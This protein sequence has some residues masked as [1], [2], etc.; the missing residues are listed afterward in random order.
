MGK[1][2]RAW[3]IAVVAL[4][5]VAVLAA[6]LGRGFL[7]GDSSRP[8][9]TQWATGT[10]EIGDIR[11]TVAG[12]A[13]LQPGQ[14]EEIRAQVAG[15]ITRIRVK[16]GETVVR[17]QI[18]AELDNESVLLS[19]EQAQLAY[20]TERQRLD[21]MRRG[22][23]A[24]VSDTAVR[25][26]E[27]KVENARLTL[28][29]RQR[30]ADEL[31]VKAPVAGLV[32]KLDV[33]QGDEVPAG[34]SLLTLWEGGVA[35]VRLPVP[36]TQ[37]RQVKVGDSASVIISPLPEAAMVPLTLGEGLIYGLKVGDL[38]VA[39]FSDY[40]LS[41]PPA[42]YEGTVAS[43]EPSGNQF[44]VYCRF[45]TVPAGIADGARAAVYI[46]PS[47]RWD[48]MTS[49]DAS[50]IMH[51]AVD[52]RY[53]DTQHAA[54]KGHS[55]RVSSIGAQG[56]KDAAG[57][58]TFE[59]IL[60]LPELPSGARA[61]MTAH[62]YLST[63]AGAPVSALSTLETVARNLTTA[64]GGKVVGLTVAEGSHAV[65]GQV[66]VV[67]ENENVLYQLEQAR[68][69]LALQ[70]NSLKELTSPEY[71]EDEL[72]SQELKF[73]QAELTLISRREDADSL[74][75]R[76]PVD[77]RVTGWQTAAQIGR[78]IA[79][80]FLFCRVSNYEN[81]S[82]AINVDELDVDLLHAGMTAEVTVDALPGRVFPAEV[83][84]IA[85]EGVYQQGV[86][87]FE[88]VLTLAGSPRLRSQM[89]A[90][91]EMFVAERKGVLLVPAEAVT[92]LGEGKGEVNVIG[93]DGRAA[94][95]EIEIGLY[96]ESQV[97]VLSGLEPGAVVV[98]GVIEAS[99]EL[100]P[101]LRV[102]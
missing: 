60:E 68:N 49:F 31:I 36:E 90:Y 73:R 76:A 51:H 16:D 96:S 20:D 47:G 54:G 30:Q 98:T 40:W 81:M 66:L 72:Q 57:E 26:A 70:E 95:Q 88:V 63:A 78:K 25:A 19:L 23:A 48:G 7:A 74:Q 27:L 59:V 3:L 56:T 58:V 87:R 21:E 100:F 89:T 50:G 46:Y 41:G 4:V 17:D 61:G 97:E 33:A 102:R 75:L 93:A 84:R 71:S 15:T 18:I 52:E 55:A 77:G 42:N 38:A 24:A 86:S 32:S 1:K 83:T 5:A 8:A 6:T 45:P 11:V 12:S 101:R 29:T 53:L 67:L 28:Q 14:V 64:A 10:A 82:L 65:A 94:A 85:Q 91:A 79:V 92:F 39:N 99:D 34:G 37:V 44:R 43:W 13:A 9:G 62:A 35:R 2:P 80:G 22:L 69:D